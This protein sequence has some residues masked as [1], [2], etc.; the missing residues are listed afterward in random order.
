MLSNLTFYSLSDQAVLP[1]AYKNYPIEDDTLRNLILIIESD[2]KSDLGI[3]D[4]LEDE[5][6]DIVSVP[7]RLEGLKLTKELQPSLI[8]CDINLLELDGYRVLN[9]LREDL[10]TVKI[11]VVFI[12]SEADLHKSPRAWQ[13]GADDYLIKPV[14]IEKLLE[15]IYLNLKRNNID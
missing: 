3:F 10:E 12:A 8:I 6:F 1:K 9:D 14:Q 13:L 7:D 15:V 2:D 11:P 5:G 4:L